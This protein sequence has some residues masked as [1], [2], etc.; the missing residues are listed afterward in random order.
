MQMDQLP[1]GGLEIYGTLGPSC[2][3]EETL[4]A[5]FREGM[6]GVRLNLSHVNLDQCGI[7]LEHF[8]SA[9]KK[10]EVTPQ[11]L[12]DLRGPELRVG[13]LTQPL[14]LKE[15]EN[16]ILGEGGIPVP[17]LLLNDLPTDQDILLDDGQIL[18]RS[19]G[20]STGQVECLVKHGGI[21]KSRKSIAVPGLNLKPPTLTDSDYHNLSLAADYGVTG[22]MLP[23]VRC[24]EDLQTLRIVLQ[25]NN[26]A[27]IR[28]FAKLENRAG[29]Q[30]LPELLEY[31]DHIVIAR[32]DLGNDMPLWELPGVQKRIASLC[33][34]YG[35]PFMVVTQLL[36]SMQL[37]AVPTRAEVLDIFNAVLDGASS[38]MLTG[39]TAAGKYPV[40]A[41]RFLCRTAAQALQY[42]K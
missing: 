36:H 30:M 10:A 3:T 26:T 42:L 11:F 4:L 40:E 19:I 28:I 21:L 20:C 31:A 27:N 12:I 25:Q 16:V 13:E 5:L 34:S 37:S 2:Q 7:W 33:R 1:L 29:V 9:A 23:F 17:D 24:K 35:K 14:L 15:G 6:T 39:E 38:L 32:G 8:H 22:V 41:M 18:L